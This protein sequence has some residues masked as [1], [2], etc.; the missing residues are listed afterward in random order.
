[1][2]RLAAL[3]AHHQPMIIAY[4]DEI[5][6][7]D[8]LRVV[9]KIRKRAGLPEMDNEPSKPS[10]SK[11]EIKHHSL[12]P[13][14]NVEIQT[15]ALSKEGTS[16][17][18]TRRTGRNA[19]KEY[20]EVID[21]V[22]YEYKEEDAPLRPKMKMPPRGRVPS[23]K[24]SKPTPKT[25]L[26]RPR[27]K[28]PPK[29]D[30]GL[31]MQVEN[32]DSPSK[33][34]QVTEGNLNVPSHDDSFTLF[35]ETPQEVFQQRPLF[36]CAAATTSQP[37]FSFDIPET[38][39]STESYDTSTVCSKSAKAVPVQYEDSIFDRF[40]DRIFGPPMDVDTR[41][42]VTDR[43]PEDD[44]SLIA[45]SYIGEYYRAT[46]PARCTQSPIQRPKPGA[47]QPALKHFQSLVHLLPTSERLHQGRR[48]R[49]VLEAVVDQILSRVSSIKLPHPPLP[50][51][52]DFDDEETTAFMTEFSVPISHPP[53][54]ADDDDD[55]DDSS[56]D[57]TTVG[58]RMPMKPTVIMQTLQHWDALDAESL[59]MESFSASS[60]SD[61]S[62]L[63][64]SSDTMASKSY[65]FDRYD[66]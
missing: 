28:K 39:V 15:D 14:Y 40:M 44:D 54:T 30:I 32:Y 8:V 29:L 52:G 46:S 24:P 25:T 33:H 16:L 66:V 9:K 60:S 26:E 51:Y 10:A 58:P 61:S 20:R 1:M 22:D 18:I 31:A 27:H 7:Q 49:S 64:D 4:Y 48:S 57:T 63:S 17:P 23:N 37:S 36:M 50:D 3:S 6:D 34:I 53:T 11:K 42:M 38:K 41:S 13:K 47:K 5:M 35:P 43:G 19:K 2:Q 45:D 12:L 55:D 62:S 21:F 59:S 56:V 65:M